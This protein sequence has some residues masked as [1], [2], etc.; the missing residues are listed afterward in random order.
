[1]VFGLFVLLFDKYMWRWRPTALLF[2]LARDRA[3]PLLHGTYAG[4]LT[5]RDASKGSQERS[6]LVADVVQTWRSMVIVF[7]FTNKDGVKQAGSRS[8][9]ACIRQG[10]D[11]SRARL[12]YTYCYE[13]REPTPDG[14]VRNTVI[15]GVTVLEFRRES[16]KWAAVGRYY[17]DDSGS[18]EIQLQQKS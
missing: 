15:Y 8:E 6:E 14:G 18:G 3:P 7:E 13:G 12:E 4:Q 11:N 1:V 16:D 9:M 5:W 2:A 17:S 10:P